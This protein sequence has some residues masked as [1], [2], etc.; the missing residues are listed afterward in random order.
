MLFRSK[1]AQHALNFG[2]VC[3]LHR[4]PSLPFDEARNTPE[5]PGVLVRYSVLPSCLS[6]KRA[7][8]PAS[9]D[10]TKTWRVLEVAEIVYNGIN[11]Q[12]NRAYIALLI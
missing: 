7:T 3:V 8:R 6:M 11:R 2:R 12:N 10:T 5:I 4:A 9:A 1:R